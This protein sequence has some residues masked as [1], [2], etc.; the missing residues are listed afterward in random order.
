MNYTFVVGSRW[1]RC[2]LIE[3]RVWTGV[4]RWL[5]LLLTHIRL[6]LAGLP[7][8]EAS[9][10]GLAFCGRKGRERTDG[11][12]SR[13]HIRGAAVVLFFLLG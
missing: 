4:F 6:G 7:R 11:G 10:G 12:F 3:K 8:E 5:L 9:R 2:P 1:G 13:V